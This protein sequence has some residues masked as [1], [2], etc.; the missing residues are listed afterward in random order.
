AEGHASELHRQRGAHVP[1]A[2]DPDQRGAVLGLRNEEV[3]AGRGGRSGRGGG[4]GG[5]GSGGAGGPG[6]ACRGR[7]HML[8]G[9]PPADRERVAASSTRTTATPA[10]LAR[11]HSVRRATRTKWPSSAASG[12]TLAILGMK[13]S[14]SRIDSASPYDPYS[15]GRSTPLS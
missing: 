8:T 13:M 6:G 5:G 9:A 1:E 11:G 4:G 7:A 12:S 14:P 15:G 3:G 2:D 10:A